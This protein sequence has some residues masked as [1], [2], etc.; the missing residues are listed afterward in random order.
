MAFKKEQI[1]ALEAAMG[2]EVGKFDEM[3][4]ATEEH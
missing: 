1:T 3:Y 2:I 4:K